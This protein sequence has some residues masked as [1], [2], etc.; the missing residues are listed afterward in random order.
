MSTYFTVIFKRSAGQVIAILAVQNLVAAATSLG[1]F[2][3]CIEAYTLS[4]ASIIVGVHVAASIVSAPIRGRAVDIFGRN[5]TLIPL[6][7]ISS[8][9]LLLLAVLL[10]GGRTGVFILM[11]IAAIQPI[12]TP[13]LDAVIR[14]E[15]KYFSHSDSE[16][17]AFH[18]IDSVLEEVGF[19]AGPLLMACF[20]SFTSPSFAFVILALL[21]VSTSAW[22]VLLP[23]MRRAINRPHEPANA[24]R[25]VDRSLFR[26]LL[27]P[28]VSVELANIVIPLILMGAAI[29]AATAPIPMIVPGG[30]RNPLT[31][32]MF[33]LISAGGLIGGLWFG[34][35]KLS[36]SEKNKQILLTVWLA[37]GFLPVAIYP[38]LIPLSFS[39]FISG[40]AV[41]P[42]FINSYLLLDSAQLDTVQHEA[43]A[44]VP[45]SYNIG[46]S[47]A[48]PFAGIAADG[49]SRYSVY[50][51]VVVVC[52]SF[53][54]SLYSFVFATVFSGRR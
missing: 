1:L 24:Q 34:A 38:S 21:S 23:S 16:K 4:V 30:D 46:Y 12:T 54:Y 48:L 42:L 22:L 53:L 40:L 6:L 25:P 43:N 29:A 49:D 13:P 31:S 11:V 36:A 28:I 15:W 26:I 39:L 20:Q 37:A 9:L 45:V 44:W 3:S 32:V 19:L 33:S 2:L 10:I 41:T 8:S 14:T 51:L 50:P 18:S 47:I 27:G 35:A 17:R 5:K 52:L 7:V